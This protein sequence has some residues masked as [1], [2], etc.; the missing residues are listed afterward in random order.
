[1]SWA[2][3]MFDVLPF[4]S[5]SFLASSGS[6]PFFHVN[7]AGITRGVERRRLGSWGGL[8]GWCMRHL[9]LIVYSHAIATRDI[10]IP[11]VTQ[12][13]LYRSRVIVVL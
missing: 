2:L 1:M 3:Y 13:G 10:R 12:R 4:H 7:L 8:K 11:V 5:Q 9:L 6:R